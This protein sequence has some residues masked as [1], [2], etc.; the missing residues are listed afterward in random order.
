MKMST[1]DRILPPQGAFLDRAGAQILFSVGSS[2]RAASTH[3]S[4]SLS[5]PKPKGISRNWSVESVSV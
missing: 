2:D 1:G 5:R 4:V 3:H